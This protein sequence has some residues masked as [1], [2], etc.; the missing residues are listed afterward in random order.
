MHAFKLFVK[1]WGASAVKDTQCG[2]KL[3][4]RP[5][6]Q[7]IVPNM[8]LSRWIFDVELLYLA[9]R[10][11]MPISEVPVSWTE[12]DGSKLSLAVD[13][14]GMALD[15]MFMRLAYGLKLWS[16]HGL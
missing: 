8:R 9:E 3:F 7:L 10:F 13:S 2:F 6:A 1:F 15:L 12:V 11:C 4:T 5:A 16:V 14:V